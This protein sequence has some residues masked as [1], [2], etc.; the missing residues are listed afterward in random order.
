MGK[1]F[2]AVYI[3]EGGVGEGGGGQSWE[4]WWWEARGRGTFLVTSCMSL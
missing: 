3:K 4:W 2:S 1:C